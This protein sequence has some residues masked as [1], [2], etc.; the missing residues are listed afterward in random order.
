MID[1]NQ[2]K[3]QLKHWIESDPTEAVM[4]VDELAKLAVHGFET[5]ED[6][7]G[8]RELYGQ[9]NCF[10]VRAN[11]PSSSHYFLYLELRRLAKKLTSFSLLAELT[12]KPNKALKKTSMS[13]KGD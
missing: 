10:C 11:F 4:D 6:Y 8:S 1:I 9:E 2:D 12:K 3:K 13:L 5:C 7:C